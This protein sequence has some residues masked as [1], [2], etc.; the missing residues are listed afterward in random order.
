MKIKLE[1]IKNITAGD[2]EL[3]NVTAIVGK[4]GAG[5]TALVSA[6][7]SILTADMEPGIV[8]A[9]AA[10]AKIAL[11]DAGLSWELVV[12]KNV[13]HKSNGGKLN[14]ADALQERETLLHIPVEVASKVYGEHQAIFG[15]K[16]DKFAELLSCV[17][18]KNTV[19]LDDVLA[20]M[21]LTK[22]Q[23]EYIQKLFPSH[24]TAKITL[25]Q[26]AALGEECGKKLTELNK[27]MAAINAA[28]AAKTGM[29]EPTLSEE[30]IALSVQRKDEELQEANL[31]AQ[32]MDAYKENKE[33]R[34]SELASIREAEIEL[35]S[36][37]ATPANERYIKYARNLIQITLEKM[38]GLEKDISLLESNNARYQAILDDLASSVCPISKAL[39]C[40]TDKTVVRG[41]IE[42]GVCENSAAIADKKAEYNRE[43]DNVSRLREELGKEEEKDTQYRAYLEMKN[44]IE[45]RKAAVPEALPMPG[46]RAPDLE[47]I[48]KQ[49]DILREMLR[50]KKA[51]ADAIALKTELAQK[52]MEAEIASLFK[53]KF[54][55]KGEAYNLVMNSIT[56]F[57]E[58]SMNQTAKELG[59][60][61]IYSFAADGGLVLNVETPSGKVKA[62]E[63]SAGEKFMAELCLISMINQETGFPY[64]VI[65]NIDALDE[66][67]L[68]KI[69]QLVEQPGFNTRFKN[70]ILSGVDHSDTLDVLMK[71]PVIGVIKL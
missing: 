18:G 11:E 41:E 39:V 57:M 48:R 37:L 52:K 27:N 24:A 6:I 10:K 68:E 19:V 61:H 33:R 14:K 30:A 3:Q 13:T 38:A 17:T 59:I 20:K 67:N 35:R 2:Y 16:A 5:K 40:T 46:G 43:A 53:A 62:N 65:D 8:T 63:L 58:D 56:G 54:A 66:K 21:G 1:N 70:I 4:N 60:S 47:G 44:E 55:P 50:V 29:P 22:E 15:E 26:L 34:E 51:H 25:D 69:L 7:K 23:S 45:L 64:A 71:H 32:K 49:L 28:I 9:G 36:K 12:G 31:F 42:K